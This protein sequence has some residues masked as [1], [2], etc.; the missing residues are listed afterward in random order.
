MVHGHRTVPHCLAQALTIGVRLDVPH[1]VTE[2][3]GP[4]PHRGQNQVG[5]RTMEPPSPEDTAR[6]DHQQRCVPA[7]TTP[8]RIDEMRTELITEQP[9]GGA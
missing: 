3:G 6:L 1:T 7:R 9:V 5:L 8:R 2:L 4:V